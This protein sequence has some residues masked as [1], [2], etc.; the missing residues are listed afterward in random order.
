[1]AAISPSN[2]IADLYNNHHGWLAAWLRRKL[3]CPEQASDIAQ[4]AFVQIL[5][6]PDVLA[7]IREPRAYLTTVARRLV[8][9][10]WRRH[11][12]ER[13]YLAELAAMPEDVFPSAEEQALVLEALHAIDRMLRGLSVKARTAF[14]MSQ[15]DGMT[16]KEIAIA[17]NVSPSRVRQYMT[18]AM[19]ACYAAL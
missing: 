18:Q 10:S 19:T 9:D 16:Y 4:D 3:G 17:L 11:D 1:M 7:D 15:L 14:L 2:L 13:A 8:F 5:G 6:R 12:L